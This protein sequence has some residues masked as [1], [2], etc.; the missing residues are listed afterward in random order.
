MNNAQK[1]LKAL[2]TG[3]TRTPVATFEQRELYADLEVA[4]IMH[5]NIKGNEPFKVQK[6]GKS[7]PIKNL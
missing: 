6:N 1:F 7:Y 2:L 5:Q 4:K 3:N